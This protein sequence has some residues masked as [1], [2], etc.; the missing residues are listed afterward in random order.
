M[1]MVL[2]M[3]S[4]AEPPSSASTVMPIMPSWA[5]PRTAGHGNSPD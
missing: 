2:E 5:R 4:S 3:V 1:M